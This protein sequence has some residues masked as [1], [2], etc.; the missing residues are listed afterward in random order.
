MKLRMAWQLFDMEKDPQEMKDLASQYPEIVQQ[1]SE[2]HLEW[3]K[4]LAPLGKVPE[5]GQR[6][7]PVAPDGY[8]WATIKDLNAKP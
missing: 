3:S 6:T 4:T 8:G 5:K 7:L 2:K 1:L